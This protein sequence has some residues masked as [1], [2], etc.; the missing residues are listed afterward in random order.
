[1]SPAVVPDA[2][3]LDVYLFEGP[4][5]QD[6]V[7]RYNLF[8][9]GGPVPP[10]WGLGIWYRGLGDYTQQ[11]SLAL[12]RQLRDDH[13]PCDVWGVEPGWQTKAYSCSF[14]W[15][16]QKFPKPDEFIRDLKAMGY[17]TNFWE[18]AFTHPE[19]PIHDALKPLP[20][21]RKSGAAS[22]PISPPR[23]GARYSSICKRNR[24]SRQA[25]TA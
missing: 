8:A 21:T 10:L 19:S 18:H 17:R 5:M 2:E 6:A 16:L 11:E 4:T 12:A 15:N 14:V 25:L 7:R 13:M 3:G 9:G 24:F 20:A 22:S 23:R 1:M